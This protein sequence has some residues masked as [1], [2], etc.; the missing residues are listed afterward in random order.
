LALRTGL[1]TTAKT[2]NDAGK[3]TCEIDDKNQIEE[4]FISSQAFYRTPSE[5]VQEIT[6]RVQFEPQ[7]LKSFD[8]VTQEQDRLSPCNKNLAYGAETPAELT[9]YKHNTSYYSTE[10]RQAAMCYS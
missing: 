3:N 9:N 2:R 5:R 7:N 4:Q 8:P 10:Q 1:G 6:T